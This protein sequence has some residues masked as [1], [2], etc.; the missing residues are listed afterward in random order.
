M[1]KSLSLY[2][3]V[4]T[5]F[6]PLGHIEALVLTTFGLDIKYLETAILPALFPHLGEGPATEPHRPLFEYLEDSQIPI[7]I[8]YDANNLVRGETTVSDSSSVIKE[9]RWQ[10]HPILRTS[11]CFHPKLILALV[12]H[13]GNRSVVVGCGS[14]NLT[15][16]GWGRNFEAYALET[17]SLSHSAKNSLLT[18]IQAL[19][20]RL[21]SDCQN[22][23]ALACLKESIDNAAPR[24]QGTRVQDGSYR[25]RL[26]FGQ[27]GQNLAEWLRREVIRGDLRRENWQLEILSPYYSDKPPQLVEWLGEQLNKRKDDSITRLYCYCP[28]EGEL[29]DLD[30]KVLA[31]YAEFPFVE[32]AELIGESLQ[33]KLRDQHGENLQRF[34]HAKVYRFWTPS[35]EVVAVGSANATIQGHRDGGRGNDEAC[36]VFSRM[37]PQGISFKPWLKPLNVNVDASLC[38]EIPSVSEDREADKPIPQVKVSFDWASKKFLA[39]SSDSREII[40][41]LGAGKT[42][43]C[44]LAPHDD[45]RA[46]LEGSSIGALFRSPS[47]RVA[48]A[49][50]DDAWICLV[51][52]L[53]LYAKPPAPSMERSIDDL[54]R[55]WQIG[56]EQRIAE[57]IARAAMPD[58]LRASSDFGAP[59][60]DEGMVQD[61]LN[62]IFLAAFRFRKDIEGKLQAD[63]SSR[64]FA[65]SQVQSRLFGNG[66][67][68]LRYFVNKLFDGLDVEEVEVRDRSAPLQPLEA[69]LAVL[70]LLD[71][72]ELLSPSVAKAGFGDD[73][74]L[75]VKDL[76]N[77]LAKVRGIVLQLVA[78][79]SSS[80]EAERVLGWVERHWRFGDTGNE[81][82]A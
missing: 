58:D 64:A 74:H 31:S 52:E 21:S 47:V 7:S 38:K 67:M 22:S 55:D 35:N 54:I 10:A 8:L 45:Y 75:L 78:A 80:E 29:V 81:G 59:E 25:T 79:E 33:S 71:A 5:H 28:R 56:S 44:T 6:Q 37:A 42:P 66:A 40:L 16:P 20:N 2:E 24:R 19:I 57:R 82:V 49:G 73:L 27:D 41:L 11:G 30:P 77:R 23:I 62:D 13:E 9:L 1:D 4:S 39:K 51:E 70:S 18:D 32:W 48:H 61:R 50:G 43:L 60:L 72:V 46:T 12:N 26:W 14:A 53:N 68:S 34:L 15:Q 17:V 36:L 69:Y 3:Q 76:K 63:E 65:L